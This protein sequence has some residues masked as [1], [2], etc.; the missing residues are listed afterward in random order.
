MLSR[1]FRPIGQF[2]LGGELL[3]FSDGYTDLHWYRKLYRAV[4]QEWLWFSRLRMS[5]QELAGTIHD[6]RVDLYVLADGKEDKG[7]LELDRRAAAEVEIA[8]FGLTADLLGQGA[9]RY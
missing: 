7:L 3:T 9:G 6:E 1:P 8:Y 5:D 2:G 4:G